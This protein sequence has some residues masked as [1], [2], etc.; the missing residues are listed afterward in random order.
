MLALAFKW[1]YKINKKYSIKT[2]FYK[3]QLARKKS[4]DKQCP[5]DN[6]DNLGFE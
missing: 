3:M 5:Q 6:A 4:L 2:Y 1:I